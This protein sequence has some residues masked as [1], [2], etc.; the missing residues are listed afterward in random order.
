MK[1]TQEIRECTHC[2]AHLP[3]GYNPVFEIHKN[4]KIVIIGQ[5]PGIVVHRIGIG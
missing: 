5:A 2:E 3:M 1:L 4:S